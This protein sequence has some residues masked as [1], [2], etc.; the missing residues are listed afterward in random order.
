MRNYA[1]NGQ[2]ESSKAQ[3]IFDLYLLS[4][5][6]DKIRKAILN[7]IAT[8]QEYTWSLTHLFDLAKLLSRFKNKEGKWGIPIS[9][10][11]KINTQ[12]WERFP[13]VSPDDNFFFKGRRLL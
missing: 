2:P 5:K 10:G 1:Y 4:D 7:G 11:D 3:Y 6:K 12:E 8:E 9:M 13:V